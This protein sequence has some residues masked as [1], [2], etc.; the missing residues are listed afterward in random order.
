MSTQKRGSCPVC[1]KGPRDKALAVKVDERGTV[2]FCH[3]CGFTRAANYEHRPLV[4]PSAPSADPLEWSERAEHIWRR[5]RPLHGT[6]GATYLQHR[7]GVL[8]PADSD[9]RFLEATDR[10]PPSLC[11]RISDGATNRPL[12]LHF[13]R[14]ALDGRGKAGTD[15]DKLLLAG[16]RKKGGVIRLWPNESVTYGLAI[17]EG[18]ETA[19]VCARLYTPIWAAVDCRNLQCFPVLDGV[20]CLAIYADHDTAGMA[21]ATACARRWREADREV[22]VYRSRQPGEDVADLL[23]RL[24]K[25]GQ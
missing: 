5:T 3:R 17:T 12:S 18:I 14:L 10:Y 25:E 9:L 13:T 6:L 23:R 16:H 4:A 21:A 22:A 8:P 20:D 7:G 24:D 2:E 15:C 11:A 19:L 1:N